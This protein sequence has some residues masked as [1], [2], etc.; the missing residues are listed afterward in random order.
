MITDSVHCE[1]TFSE[2]K[3]DQRRQQER[4]QGNNVGVRHASGVGGGIKPSSVD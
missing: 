1:S 4:A 3:T 2:N